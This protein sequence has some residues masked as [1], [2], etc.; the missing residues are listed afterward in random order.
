VINLIVICAAFAFVI[1]LENL[2]FM[3]ER[4]EL[5]RLLASKN[6]TEYRTIKG[7]EPVRP[8]IQSAAERMNKKWHHEDG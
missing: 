2:I 7:D 6:A 8:A 4:R 3:V 5:Y 1:L